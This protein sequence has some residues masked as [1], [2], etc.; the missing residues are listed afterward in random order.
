M[1]AKRVH[2][3]GLYVLLVV[4][5]SVSAQEPIY[6]DVFQKIM[7]EA[8]ENSRV[9]EN[10]SWLCDVFGPRNTK[11]KAYF[12]SAQWAK[13]RLEVYGLS[14]ARLEPYEFGVGWSNEYTSVH[15]MSP[16]YMPII[17]HPAG[18]SAGTDGKI[19]NTVTYINFYEMTKES[20]LDRYRGK[21]QDAI[22][23][24]RPQQEITPHYEPMAKI[25]TKEQLDEM[26]K[27]PIG[28]RTERRR[29]R[30]SRGDGLTVTQVID[31][32]FA[33]GAAA[34]VR[35][36]GR[37]DFGT[38]DAAVNGYA[39]EKRAWD[40]DAP[41]P[42][43]ELVMAAE[44]YNRIL[45]ILEMTEWI[46]PLHQLG[47]SHLFTTGMAHE[48]YTEVGLP[49]FYFVQDRMDSRTYHSNMDVYDHLV[50]ENLMTN[51]VI[52]ATL[53]YHAAMRDEKLPRVEHQEW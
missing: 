51:S 40:T 23:F 45:R 10:A 52:L 13:K 9:M 37:N 25:Y 47:M 24:M 4:V 46:K 16:Q 28:P 53:V 14:N 17:A 30:R 11:T 50:P 43:T 36:D 29:R 15:M 12:E 31:F 8:F 26:A 41:P 44:H 34:I 20:D 39:M 21:L 27:I 7:E 1:R 18:W 49:G 2:K 6:W 38:V 22:I 48:A 42:V 19:R 3:I 32:V 33:E 35:T 5:T